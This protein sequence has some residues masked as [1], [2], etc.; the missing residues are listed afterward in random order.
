VDLR[1]EAGWLPCARDQRREPR[2]A[3][4]RNNNDLTRTYSGVATAELRLDVESAVLD[5]E[6]V[7]VGPDGRPSFQALQHRGA[8]RD[9][10]IVFYAF[11]LLHL[12]AQ[13][14]DQ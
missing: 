9:H 8:P 7:A 12:N 11:D 5:G 6:I 10:T 4:S 14:F 1:G 2:P 3:R 13:D